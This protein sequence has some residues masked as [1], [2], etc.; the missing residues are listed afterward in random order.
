MRNKKSRP[1]AEAVRV[2]LST[3]SSIDEALHG[4]LKRLLVDDTHALLPN[5]SQLAN[6][7]LETMHTV[8]SR[9]HSIDDLLDVLTW[10][11]KK[12]TLGGK[13]F[14]EVEYSALCASLE[15][16][17]CWFSRTDDRSQ[18]SLS[19]A[20]FNIWFRLACEVILSQRLYHSTD[21]GM[22]SWYTTTADEDTHRLCEDIT[23]AARQNAFIA[24]VSGEEEAEYVNAACMTTAQSA[25]LMPPAVST[26]ANAGPPMLG[27]G[28]ADAGNHHNDHHRGHDDVLKA[29][30]SSWSDDVHSTEIDRRLEFPVNV[31]DGELASE[32]SGFGGMLERAT[33]ET[34]TDTDTD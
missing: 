28:V 19:F 16:L 26:K 23:S 12:F 29:S 8:V 31:P 9:A 2:A 13:L 7:S 22:S 20:V 30:V 14:S 27:L 4:A 1:I 34:Q 33:M 10:L 15:Q 21:R 17:C 6:M 24:S 3:T 32:L 5:A 11:R 25:P 18:T